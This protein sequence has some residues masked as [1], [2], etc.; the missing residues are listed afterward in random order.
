MKSTLAALVAVTVL[1]FGLV[2]AAGATPTALPQ[3]FCGLF[4]MFCD[5]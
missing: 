1:S 2:P 3:W 5:R 4:P